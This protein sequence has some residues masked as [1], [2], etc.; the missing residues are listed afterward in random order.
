MK[1]EDTY[2][3]RPINLRNTGGEVDDKAKAKALADFNLCLKTGFMLEPT[4][5]A[6]IQHVLAPKN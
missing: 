3:G 5:V 2:M 6:V 4:T 1:P